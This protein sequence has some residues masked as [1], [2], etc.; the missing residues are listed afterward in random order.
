MSGSVWVEQLPR[1]C[2]IVTLIY[3]S[4]AVH[5]R[6]MVFPAIVRVRTEAELPAAIAEAARRQ[7]V[8][9]SEF[10]RQSVRAAVEQAGVEL[11]P[12]GGAEGDSAQ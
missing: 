8:T 10:L 11:P 12:I 4:F 9:S 2:V 5:L 6:A 1:I 7:R 3:W